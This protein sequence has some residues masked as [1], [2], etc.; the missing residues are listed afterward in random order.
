[1]GAQVVHD[2]GGGVV[3][4]LLLGRAAVVQVPVGGAALQL[5]VLRRAD[6]VDVEVRIVL[7]GTAP[8]SRIVRIDP[9]CVALQVA[10]GRLFRLLTDWHYKSGMECKYEIFSGEIKCNIKQNYISASLP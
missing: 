3:L 7:V 4:A 5:G 1:M 10:L 8:L 9:D 6:L 2:V